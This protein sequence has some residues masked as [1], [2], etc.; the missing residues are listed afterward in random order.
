MRFAVGVPV[1]LLV[2]MVVSTLVTL[3]YPL[4]APMAFFLTLSTTIATAILF[5]AGFPLKDAF[6]TEEDLRLE[7]ER[8][9]YDE[10]TAALD[11]RAR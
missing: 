11:A 1:G 7:R 6:T 10:R 3:V 5:A 2:S 4:T 9:I 8:R